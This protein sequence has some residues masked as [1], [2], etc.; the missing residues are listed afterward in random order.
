MFATAAGPG[1]LQM[2]PFS[3]VT[4]HRDN[5][6][7]NTLFIGNLGDAVSEVEL[8]ALFATQPGYR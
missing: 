3:P 8:R 4:N 2:R 7:C 1:P 6:P 5:A